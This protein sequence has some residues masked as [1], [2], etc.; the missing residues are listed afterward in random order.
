MNVW[1][2]ST[3]EVSGIWTFR[4]AVWLLGV[5]AREWSCWVLGQFQTLFQL[6]RLTAEPQ[7]LR[8]LSFYI[9][10]TLGLTNFSCL[11]GTVL[12]F[13]CDSTLHF[14]YLCMISHLCNYFLFTSFVSYMTS[15][16]VFYGLHFYLQFI[17]GENCKIADHYGPKHWVGK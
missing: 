9:V 3:L 8:V 16:S 10:D 5:N 14:K 15:P 6:S 11:S 17:L 2:I 1:G 13:Y 7:C 4:G 12:E